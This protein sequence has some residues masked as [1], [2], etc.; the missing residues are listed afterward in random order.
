MEQ[1]LQQRT[2]EHHQKTTKLEEERDAAKEEVALLRGTSIGRLSRH[3]L[4]QLKSAHQEGM[5]RVDKELECRGSQTM[6]VSIAGRMFA[7]N[8]SHCNMSYQEQDLIEVL[9]HTRRNGHIPAEL[10]H[11]GA[12]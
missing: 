12:F 11:G 8:G 6:T 5:R 1:E 3:E 9:R 2:R 4:Q 7:Y 10:K